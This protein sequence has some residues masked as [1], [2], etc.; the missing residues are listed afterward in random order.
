MKLTLRFSRSAKKL[1]G[2]TAGSLAVVTFG[3]AA[4]ANVMY[5]PAANP[6]ALAGTRWT[7]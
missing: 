3:Q 7:P 5:N 4:F 6:A 1:G 2:L